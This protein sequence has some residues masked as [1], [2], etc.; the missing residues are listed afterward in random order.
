VRRLLLILLV[1]GVVVA[2]ASGPLAAAPVDTT[3]TETTPVAGGEDTDVGEA[4]DQP[5]GEVVV[6]AAGQA[7]GDLVVIPAGC[8]TAD[9][10]LAVFAGT[11]MTR[12]TEAARFS[13]EQV[14]AGSL[15][16]FR[17]GDLIDVRYGDDA[18]YLTVGDEYVIGVESAGSGVLASK[19]RA[20]AELFGGDAV[21]GIN[22]S[23][24]SCPR[25][26]DPVMTLHA[27]GTAVDVGVLTPLDG[28]RNRLLR[29]VLL[30]VA[31]ALCGLAL[32]ASIKLL[33]QA[34]FRSVLHT[35]PA[36]ARRRRHRNAP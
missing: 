8:A 21:I 18:R 11:L 14:R 15:D 7:P 20:P 34:A 27:D 33:G 6:P 3:P 36:P 31:L 2:T 28:A 30:P 10:A 26:E 32:L 17:L 35:D 19:V 29:A 25:V 4:V 22:D 24:V 9:P 23:D 13:I 12:S 16:D 1:G 5:V